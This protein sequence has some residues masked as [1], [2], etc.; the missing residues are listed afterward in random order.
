MRLG[1]PSASRLLA[2]LTRRLA[3]ALANQISAPRDGRTIPPRSSAHACL[4]PG[5]LLLAA[6]AGRGRLTG[7]WPRRA[8]D[9]APAT[10]KLVQLCIVP[11]ASGVPASLGWGSPSLLCSK[12]Q[13]ATCNPKGAFVCWVAFW[14]AVGHA[15]RA[16]T[17]RRWPELRAGS[18]VPLAALVAPAGYTSCRRRSRA[19]AAECGLAQAR[20]PFGPRRQ[21][22]MLRCSLRLCWTL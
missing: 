13:N 14:H 17:R 21:M 7:R 5:R 10:A 3:Q 18:H 8:P 16:V 20:R 4:P 12:K 2:G 1:A 9:E 11:C 22:Q 6:R 15:M 19:G